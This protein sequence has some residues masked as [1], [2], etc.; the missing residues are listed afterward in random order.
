[1]LPDYLGVDLNHAERRGGAGLSSTPL[2][3]TGATF[4]ILQDVCGSHDHRG[5]LAGEQLTRAHPI[6]Q[7]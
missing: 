4:R 1:M 3:P 5:L 6:R 7:L 2:R